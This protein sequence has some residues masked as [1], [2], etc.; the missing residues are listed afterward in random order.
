[1]GWS[2]S[3]SHHQVSSYIWQSGGSSQ[4]HFSSYYSW[5]ER[6]M[7]PKLDKLWEALIRKAISYVPENTPL[8]IKIDDSSRKKRGKKI[9]GASSYRN[10]APVARQE[11]RSIYGI[12]IVIATLDIPIRG[13]KGGYLPIGMGCAV[14]VKSKEAQELGQP[15]YRRSELARQMVDRIAK[16]AP[17][18]TLW[19]I[20]DGAYATKYFLRELPSHVTVISRL[21][22]DS[23]IYAQPTP[24]VP[25]TPG[26]QAKK[27]KLIG[28]AKRLQ[29]QIPNWHDHSQ[30]RHTQWHAVQGLWHTVLPT[31]LL[32]GVMVKRDSDYS[33]PKK[34]LEAFFSTDTSL[35]AEDILRIY[36]SRW[37]I[38]IF[39][40]EAYLLYG[41]AQ[42]HCRKYPRLVAIN[43][44]RLL[45][46]AVQV[47]WF[48]DTCHTVGAPRLQTLRPWYRQ[49]TLPSLRDV[50]TASQEALAARGITPTSGFW[51]HVSLF[52]TS[53]DP[54]DSMAA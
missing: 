2:L 43:S 14:Y 3:G 1:M 49:K 4:K 8:V 26:P 35:A 19:V 7:Y 38:E 5:L 45:F 44:L 11:Q 22:I 24:K 25:G 17:E 41:L 21:P 29:H 20:A 13:R 33:G 30:E 46:A 48:V 31:I 6:S 32:H 52:D 27:G 10:G 36:A 54:V 15:Y 40:R 42:D 9:E 18:R 34:A 51:D 39:F 23:K 28:S 16:L 53:F 37:G 12:N 47:F 50:F